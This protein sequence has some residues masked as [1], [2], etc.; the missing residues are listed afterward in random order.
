MTDF[1]ERQCPLTLS[2]V[3]NASGREPHYKN[4][5]PYAVTANV[6]INTSL[7][8]LLDQKNTKFGLFLVFGLLGARIC[9]VSHPW[10]IDIRRRRRPISNA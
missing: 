9:F 6:K 1:G 10:R 7:R 5:K 4:G 3:E 2:F 8:L